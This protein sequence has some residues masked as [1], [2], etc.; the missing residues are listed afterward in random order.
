[1]EI[2]Q[3]FPVTEKQI[4]HLKWEGVGEVR[5]VDMENGQRWYVAKDVLVCLGHERDEKLNMRFMLG[6]LGVPAFMQRTIKFFDCKR[7]CLT[8]DGVLAV[9]EK[10][11]KEGKVNFG[12][13]FVRK[14][15]SLSDQNALVEVKKPE[16][17]KACDLE[18]F[19]F[20][21]NDIRCKLDKKG[22]PWF[23]ARDVCQCLE[24]ANV[25]QAL[26]YLDDDEIVTII[27]NDSMND[28]SGLR[29][30]TKLVS[31][32]GLYNLIFRS[33]KEEAKKFRKWVTSEV[34]PALRKTGKYEI[35]NQ[36]TET[37]VTSN[38]MPC[39]TPLQE[40]RLMKSFIKDFP[41][42]TEKEA[43][44]LS[45]FFKRKLGYSPLELLAEENPEKS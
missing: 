39:I 19:E 29:K 35:S 41:K 3:N 23:V 7:V 42:L 10:S 40:Y 22:D 26:S 43:T 44:F 14:V 15:Q 24:I 37:K 2:L 21:G 30:D 6:G 9:I 25:A 20:R 11:K 33:R 13:W 16:T 18:Y 45:A 17:K 27:S 34:L 12:R 1:M 31:E 32:S 28:F 36:K 38:E 5:A 8:Y 4:I